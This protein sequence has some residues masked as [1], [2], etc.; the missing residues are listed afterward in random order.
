[1]DRLKLAAM[2]EAVGRLTQMFALLDFTL[3]AVVWSLVGDGQTGKIVTGGV[4]MPRLEEMAV[5]LGRYKYGEDHPKFATLKDAVGKTAA[6]RVERNQVIHSMLLS[7]GRWE[8]KPIFVSLRK[9]KIISREPPTVDE[10]KAVINDT[11]A[12]IEALAAFVAEWVDV[13]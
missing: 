2:D 6:A 3:H 5:E 7:V 8:E 12:A 13:V 1:M 4:S 11:D 9:A 10:I